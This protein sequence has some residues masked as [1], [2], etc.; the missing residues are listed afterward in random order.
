MFGNGERLLKITQRGNGERPFVLPKHNNY[1]NS[2]LSAGLDLYL[3]LGH[4]VND[5]SSIELLCSFILEF[6]SYIKWS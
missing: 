1:E 6:P 3:S 5:N 4:K 2:R